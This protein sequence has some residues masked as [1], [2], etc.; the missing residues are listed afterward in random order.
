MDRSIGQTGEYD[1]CTGQGHAFLTYLDVYKRQGQYFYPNYGIFQVSESEIND[2][3]P[4]YKLI[5]TLEAK[6]KNGCP[7]GASECGLALCIVVKLEQIIEFVES[8]K[9][10]IKNF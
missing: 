1:K 6:E 8:I 2:F 7:Y 4:L 5:F 9:S 10:Q 3:E